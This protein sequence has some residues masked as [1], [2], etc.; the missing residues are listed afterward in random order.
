MQQLRQQWIQARDTRQSALSLLVCCSDEFLV[1]QELRSS[2]G[3]E[4]GTG[5]ISMVTLD[6]DQLQEPKKVLD[7]VLVSIYRET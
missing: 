2:V 3:T 6:S 7:E 1:L 4:L 5:G